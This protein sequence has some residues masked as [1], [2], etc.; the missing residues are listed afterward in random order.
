MERGLFDKDDDEDE[1]SDSDEGAGKKGIRWANDVEDH[2]R[3][4]GMNRMNSNV[5]SKG[6]L[7]T[8]SMNQTKIAWGQDDFK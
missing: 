2:Q 1:D 6:G 8:N 3:K 4:D 5:S 7:I